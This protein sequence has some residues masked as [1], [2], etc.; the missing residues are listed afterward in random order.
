MFLTCLRCDLFTEHFEWSIALANVLLLGFLLAVSITLLVQSLVDY[1]N[2]RDLN[3][4]GVVTKGL[5]VDKWV[6]V[7][8]EKPVYRVRYKYLT[9]F[10]TVQIV[11]KD[12]LQQLK[13]DENVQVLHL[14]Q[15][16]HISRLDLD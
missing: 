8:D 12:I 2:T 14:T 1:R 6:D 10:H 5:L 16:P 7:S 4:L 11:G 3:R 9:Q 15:L 13:R